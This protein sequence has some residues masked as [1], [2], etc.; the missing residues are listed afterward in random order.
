MQSCIRVSLNSFLFPFPAQLKRH[1]RELVRVVDSILLTIESDVVP[2]TKAK[3]AILTG[4]SWNFHYGQAVA[5]PSDFEIERNI[6][7]INVFLLFS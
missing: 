2:P 7:I 1:A 3:R 5:Q 4:E 6:F